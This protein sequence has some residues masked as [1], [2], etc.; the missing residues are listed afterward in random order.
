[1]VSHSFRVLRVHG[2]V[3]G[4]RAPP[5]RVL[6]PPKPWR[7]RYGSRLCTANRA[8]GHRAA[9]HASEGPRDQPRREPLRHVRRDRRRP[10]G[11]ALVFPGRRR[12]WDDREEHLG[13]RH[14]RKRRDL[15]T[16]RALRLPHAARQHAGLRAR[17]EPHAPGPFARRQ[18]G[19]LHVRGHG[20]GA[21]L[22]RHERVP[23]LDGHPLPVAA[24]RGGQRDHPARAHARREK[25]CCSKR[26]WA[27][28]A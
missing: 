1:M 27:S 16:H 22:P 28:S 26:R 24:R 12:G 2:K 9:G 19:V 6:T 21:Q 20:V 4:P 23:R 14:G 3:R 17:P 7:N 15:R 11:R 18:D 10:R 8:H 25:P 13:L 5:A